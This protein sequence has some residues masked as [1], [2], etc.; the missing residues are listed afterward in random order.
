MTSI[1]KNVYINRLDDIRLLNYTTWYSTY[2]DYSI[3]SNNKG[4][5]FEVGERAKIS[6]CKITF[7]K[8]YNPNWSEEI[9]IIKR[10]KVQPRGHILLVILTGE[11]I[12]D[13]IVW[14]RPLFFLKCYFF[15]IKW[16]FTCN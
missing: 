11:E 13:K 8:G 9:F 1:S 2:N 15:I 3:K 5:K 10:L 4:P 12:V 6:K 7:A 16:G 14:T